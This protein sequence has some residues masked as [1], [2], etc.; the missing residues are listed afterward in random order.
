VAVSRTVSVMT[1]LLGMKMRYLGS[2]SKYEFSYSFRVHRKLSF[3]HLPTMRQTLIL[4]LAS[5]L[6]LVLALAS[7]PQGTSKW[8]VGQTV[9]TSSGPVHEHKARNASA[10]SEYLGIPYVS[11]FNSFN[12]QHSTI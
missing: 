6:G 7:E 3:H 2:I 4:T 11:I 9:Q 12:E 5:V 10:V 1:S 8:T